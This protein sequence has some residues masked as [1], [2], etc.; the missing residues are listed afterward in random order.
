M[1]L[2]AGWPGI[3]GSQK[4]GGTIA[5]QQLAEIGSTGQYVV[6]RVIWIAA[7]GGEGACRGMVMSLGSEITTPGSGRSRYGS[8]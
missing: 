8:S 5:I 7:G 4:P 3:I 2:I 6:V 1:V